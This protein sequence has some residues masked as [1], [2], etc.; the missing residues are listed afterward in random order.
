MR[1]L[2]WL[3]VAGFLLVGGAAIAAAASAPSATPS[4][5]SNQDTASPAPSTATAS[6]APSSD[7]NV[8]EAGKPPMEFGFAIIDAGADLLDEVLADLVATGTITQAQSDA[9]TQALAQAITDRQADLEQQREQA[10]AEWAQM[11]G[12]L[13]D[14]VIT[15]DEVNELPEDSPFREVFNSIAQDGQITL[16]QLAAA[17]PV[18]SGRLGKGSRSRR[19]GH[20]LPRPWA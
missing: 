6:A 2:I 20:A 11:K 7:A 15:Q 18:R 14:G 17:E 8:G 13:E 5:L 12:F 19:S 1:R 10:E 4:S 16:D 3:P 9:I